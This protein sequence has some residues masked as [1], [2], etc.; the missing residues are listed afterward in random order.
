MQRPAGLG[1]IFFADLVIVLEHEYLKAAQLLG[2]LL[3]PFARAGTVCAACSIEAEAVERERI[4]L[5]FGYGDAL[6]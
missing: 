3:P 2:I 4:L 1:S 5:T 6:L